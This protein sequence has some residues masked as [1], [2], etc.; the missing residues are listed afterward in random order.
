M[1]DKKTRLERRGCFKHCQKRKF[2]IHLAVTS[3]KEKGE[4]RN[5]QSQASLKFKSLL[6]GSGGHRSHGLRERGGRQRDTGMETKTIKRKFSSL[7]GIGKMGFYPLKLKKIENKESTGD[8]TEK[9]EVL[10]RDSA[11]TWWWLGNSCS[12]YICSHIRV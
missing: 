1:E 12:S 8:S 9:T 3:T 4:S 7:K 11:I 10:E 5:G 6:W 2:E